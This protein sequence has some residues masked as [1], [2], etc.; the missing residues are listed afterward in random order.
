MSRILRGGPRPSD[1]SPLFSASRRIPAEV[2]AARAEAARLLEEARHEAEAIRH[3]ARQD[4]ARVLEGARAEGRA[5]GHAEAAAACI[6]AAGLRDGA[7]AEAE[8]TIARLALSAAERLFGESL[9]VS[10]ERIAAIVGDG[11]SRARRARD[12]VVRVHPDDAGQLAS[13]KASIA[14]RAGCPADFAVR[15]DPALTRGGCVVETELG[16]V[17][18]R[19]ETRLDALA[20]ALGL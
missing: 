5:G 14:A 1:D 18:A 4:A 8:R 16:T 2:V 9:D 17:D 7:L 6:E 15:V 19:L 20:R 11:L 12:V 13:L 3:A 10:P